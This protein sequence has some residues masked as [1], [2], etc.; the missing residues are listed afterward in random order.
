MTSTEDAMED[1][2]DRKPDGNSMLLHIKVRDSLLWLKARELDNEVVLMK[3]Q[4]EASWHVRMLTHETQVAR[5]PHHALH[6]PHRALQGAR[7]H[8]LR[9]QPVRMPAGDEMNLTH[10]L[11][12]DGG[13]VV[14]G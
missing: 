9:R 7:P 1:D 3:R 6:H 14:G 10:E 11:R 12:R 5:M 4:E 2:I 13:E 8:Q